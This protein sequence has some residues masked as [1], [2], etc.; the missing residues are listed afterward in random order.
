MKSRQRAK[1]CATYNERSGARSLEIAYLPRVS[2]LV[3][4]ERRD[5]ALGRTSGVL[6]TSAESEV[7]VSVLPSV[8]VNLVGYGEW[9]V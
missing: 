9:R 4:G 1:D 6:T 5:P 3:Q 8:A 7:T 2:A